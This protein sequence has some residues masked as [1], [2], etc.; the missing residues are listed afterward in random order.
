MAKKDR[1]IVNNPLAGMGL[2]EIVRG[3][4]AADEASS[5]AKQHSE[6]SAVETKTQTESLEEQ[7]RAVLNS[8]DA[9]FSTPRKRRS[10][11]SKRLEEK[12]AKYKNIGEQ[13][14][15]IWLPRD[16]KKRLDMIRAN[17]ERNIP[18]RALAAAIIMSYIEENEDRLK[19][20]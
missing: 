17:S 13:G 2:D 4:T 9:P 19:E 1:P 15:A 20:L 6:G 11:A 3:I 14:V 18:I 7:S 10:S 8:E 12:L 16:V 5:S